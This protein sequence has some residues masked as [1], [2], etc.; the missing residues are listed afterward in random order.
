M[1]V[2]S[3]KTGEVTASWGKDNAISDD[4]LCALGR[5]YLNTTNGSPFEGSYYSPEA[6]L[7]P[8]DPIGGPFL[9]PSFVWDRTNPWA[10]YTCTANNI[11]NTGPGVQGY[12]QAL[13]KSGPN[14]LT[15]PSTATQFRWKMF[16]SWS[17]LVFD[18][19]LKAIGLTALQSNMY[20]YPV[21]G[22]PGNGQ[23]SNYV[24][25]TLVILPSSI[26]VHGTNGGVGTPDILEISYFLSVV[27]AS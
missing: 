3:S 25:E 27:G 11:T 2:K 7:L 10:P 16:Y 18:I 14:N 20:D 8:D 4:F 26:L 6:F 21:F 24:P 9:W 12:F 23:P 13:T 15:P 17:D 1:V 19:Q 5:I 22:V